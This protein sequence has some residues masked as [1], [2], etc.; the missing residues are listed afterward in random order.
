[1]EG[2][3]LSERGKRLSGNRENESGW[4]EILS[5]SLK[6]LSD[7]KK[8]AIREGAMLSG[9]GKTQSGK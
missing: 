1:M 6:P 8:T 7:F 5:G 9:R 3:I 2:K 4:Q